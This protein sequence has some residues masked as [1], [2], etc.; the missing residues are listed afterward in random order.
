MNKYLIYRSLYNTWNGTK[1][2]KIS[3]SITEGKKKVI[4]GYR[5]EKQFCRFVE[6]VD[7]KVG[8]ENIKEAYVLEEEDDAS[9]ILIYQ[10]MAD[11]LPFEENIYAR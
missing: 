6:K 4:Y 10:T 5:Y 1:I 2:L 9:A 7:V 11:E 3:F 8:V